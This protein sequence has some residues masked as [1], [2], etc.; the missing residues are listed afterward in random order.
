M[1]KNSKYVPH[2]TVLLVSL[3]DLYISLPSGLSIR[4]SSS[5]LS[6]STYFGY[7]CFVGHR[8]VSV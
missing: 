4:A 1:R 7:P 8:V 6:A 5:S 2:A 3:F